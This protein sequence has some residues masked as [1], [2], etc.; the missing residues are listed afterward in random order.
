MNKSVITAGFL[1]I[2]LVLWM[3]SGLLSDQNAADATDTSTSDSQKASASSDNPNT[4]EGTN[5]LLRV[6]TR[7]AVASKISRTV[8]LQGQLE[9]IRRLHLTSQAS[10]IVESLPQLRGKRIKQ[11]DLLVKLKPGTLDSDLA[12]ANAGVAAA[13]SEQQAAARLQER[14]LQSKNALTQAN[15]TLASAVAARDRIRLQITHT[16]ILAPFDGILN[17]LP[18][19]IGMLVERGTTVADIID[20]SKFKMAATVAQQVISRISI[21]QSIEAELITGESLTGKIS[22]ISSIADADTRSF[23]VEAE[24]DNSNRQLA[25]GTSASLIVPLE[26]VEAT[27][28]SP[29]ALSLGPDGEIGVKTVNGSSKVEFHVIDIVSTRGDGAWVTGIPNNS[30]VI[31]QGQGFVNAGEEVEPVETGNVSASDDLDST[32]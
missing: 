25:A 15:A 27:L 32:L 16:E 22:Y 24:L 14:G 2:V 23:S 29:S 7:R 11:G 21:G 28:V 9:P 18:A 8:T 4:E 30:Q 17:D 13:R 20:D 1:V 31:V 19:E 6:E 26:S 10:G 3:A 5:R 12:E